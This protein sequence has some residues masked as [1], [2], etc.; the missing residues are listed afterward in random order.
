LVP[1]VGKVLDLKS[2]KLKCVSEVTVAPEVVVRDLHAVWETKVS[3]YSTQSIV[4][5]TCQR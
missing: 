2:V 3:I 1:A 5:D 4:T